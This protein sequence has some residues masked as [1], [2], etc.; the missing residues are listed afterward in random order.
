MKRFVSS[1]FR[2]ASAGIAAFLPL[3]VHAQTFTERVRSGLNAPAEAA[4]LTESA[5]LEVMIG[6]AINVALSLLGVILL[7][8]LIFAGF[9]WMTAGGD[10]DKIKKARGI[11]FNT[12]I[13]MVIVALAYA[14]SDFVLRQLIIATQ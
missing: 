8:F 14:I 4:G 10:E 12:I 6:N 1:V 2:F 3:V 5:P 13:G 7:C 9:L 11:I